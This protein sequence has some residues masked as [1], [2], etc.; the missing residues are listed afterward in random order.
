M[1]NGHVLQ[2][3]LVL[4]LLISTTLEFLV[5][6]AFHAYGVNIIHAGP[7]ALLFSILYQYSRLVPSSY[8]VRVLGLVFTDKAFTYALAIQVR[9]LANLR[10]VLT[11]QRSADSSQS[12]MAYHRGCC[13]R[14]AQRTA[15]PLRHGRPEAL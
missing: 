10:A 12:R 15:I 7:A 11:S 2:S 9:F 4:S 3:F 5:L 8:D 14:T 13:Y 1:A 6:L